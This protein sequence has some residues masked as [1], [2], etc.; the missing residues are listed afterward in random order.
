LRSAGSCFG[1]GTNVNESFPLIAAALDQN[2]RLEIDAAAFDIVRYVIAV[3]LG[4][5]TSCCP[6]AAVDA[7]PRNVHSFRRCGICDL[8]DLLK[9][10]VGLR[11]AR[12]RVSLN[13]ISLST[14]RPP[15]RSASRS[16]S[17]SCCAPTR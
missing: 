15:K 13:S 8:N 3:L 11:L 4:C 12:A 10:F 5:Q 6:F 9:V 16:Q 2:L 1:C 14:S 7:Q 17:R